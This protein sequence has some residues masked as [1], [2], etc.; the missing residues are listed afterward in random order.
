MI[1]R[2]FM[3]YIGEIIGNYRITNI[4]GAGGYGL[5]L[6]GENINDSTLQ[7]AVK[8]ANGPWDLATQQK[9]LSEAQKIASLRHPNIVQFKDFGIFNN[10][11]YI[12]IELAAKGSL[13]DL[14]PPGSVVPLATVIDIVKQVASALQY[15]H[16]S[17]LIH[18]DLKPQN[19]LIN[20]QDEMLL[21]DFGTAMSQSSITT[22]I[23]GTL[24]YMAPE[25]IK[26][27]PE[28][29]SDQYALAIMVYEFLTGSFPFYAND[30]LALAQMQ[31]KDT[32]PPPRSINPNIPVAV[33]AVIAKS[34]A[35]N[36]KARYGSIQQFADDLE[37]AS[38]GLAPTV[39]VGNPWSTTILPVN[40]APTVPALPPSVSKRKLSIW[41]MVIPVFVVLFLSFG[42][43][44]A[45]D[46][47]SSTKSQTTN[48]E[49]ITVTQ[50]SKPEITN[51]TSVPATLAPTPTPTPS[52]TV[53][54]THPPTPTPI[55]IM[56]SPSKFSGTLRQ[57]SQ[58]TTYNVSLVITNK[59]PDGNFQGK[60]YATIKG[61]LEDVFVDGLIVPFNQSGNYSQLDGQKVSQIEQEVGSNGL[62]LYFTSTDYD[63]GTDIW[64]HCTYYA[65]LRSDGSVEGIWYAPDNSEQGPTRLH[66]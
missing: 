47:S 45:R 21:T 38:K 26:K 59:S 36:P 16:N 63:Q 4:L 8:I 22:N 42:L 10:A 1:W 20:Q 5:V 19:I 55:P 41:V 3:P 13:R 53:V 51:P 61:T 25:V 14:Y 31:L 52:P 48:Q 49:N 46:V 39:P 60:W 30:T 65:L 62:L 29:A 24:L 35:K 56:A 64:L 33:E 34:L 50:A 18:R 27:Q 15:V 28:V 58:N 11:P 17:G 40:V 12:I 6:L 37:R 66:S 2:Y 32:P 9:F 54:P 23:V 43:L 7:A 44:L 57:D